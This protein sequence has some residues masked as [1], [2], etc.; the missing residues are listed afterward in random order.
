M[1]QDQLSTREIQESDIPLIIH[2]W[3]SATDDYLLGMG[4][5][6]EKM[7][8]RDEWEK[9]FHEQVATPYP[10]KKAYCIIWLINDEPVGH[11]NVNK[12]VFGEEAYMHLHMWQDVRRKT[13]YGAELVKLTVP[14]FFKNL[15]LKN[16]YCEP[17]A[18]NPAPNK[19]LPKA[20]F[21]FVKNHI[22]TPGYLNFEQPVNLWEMDAPG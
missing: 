4:A 5:L 10:D 1:K 12:I 20:G 17:Y 19:T 9:M 13:G 16:L 21:R 18:L 6:R 15:Q 11:S 14:W 3:L 22:T 7:P 8:A 2:Y